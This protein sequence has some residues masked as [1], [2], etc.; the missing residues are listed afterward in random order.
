M[1]CTDL[2]SNWLEQVKNLLLC[3]PN[4]SLSVEQLITAQIGLEIEHLLCECST[5][6]DD[7]RAASCNINNSITLSTIYDKIKCGETLTSIEVEWAKA[8]LQLK[9]IECCESQ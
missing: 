1:D 5:I 8:M 3:G 2:T 6:L 4:G 7:D 9:W